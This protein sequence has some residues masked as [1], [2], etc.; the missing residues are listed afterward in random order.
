MD[1]LY[2]KYATYSD[3]HV[4]LPPEYT[5]P[6][7]QY[8]EAYMCGCSF[9]CCMDV[10]NAGRAALYL[11]STSLLRRSFSLF[12]TAASGLTWEIFSSSVPLM[13]D[14]WP[15]E[16]VSRPDSWRGRQTRLIVALTVGFGRGS[17]AQ[18]QKTSFGECGIKTLGG[19]NGS[20]LGQ[21]GPGFTWE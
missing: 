5:D 14:A 7:G 1:T 19:R 15:A 21:R 8:I 10:L 18:L 11:C 2:R 4:L 3:I 20:D 17:K 9:S 16:G 6:R 13:L 12:S